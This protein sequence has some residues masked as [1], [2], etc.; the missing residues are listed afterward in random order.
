MLM[1]RTEDQRNGFA[2]GRFQA[3]HEIG[4]LVEPAFELFMVLAARDDRIDS[5]RPVP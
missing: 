3:Q 4:D 2:F 5:T 1:P